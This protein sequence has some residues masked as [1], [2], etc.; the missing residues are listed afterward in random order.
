MT[1]FIKIR[2]QQEAQ[3]VTKIKRYVFSLTL[4]Q[5]YRA[6]MGDLSNSHRKNTMRS[7]SL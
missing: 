6:A 4:K 3:H 1:N 2:I 5:C 7:T